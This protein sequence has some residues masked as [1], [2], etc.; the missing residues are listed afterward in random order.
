MSDTAIVI[1]KA[2]QAIEVALVEKASADP[3]F[4]AL[5]ISDPHKAVKELL[6]SDPLPSVK[7]RVIEEAEG[8]V[9][10]VLPRQMNQDELPDEILDLASGGFYMFLGGRDP[11]H[12][13]CK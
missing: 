13:L 12:K 1:A 4:R 3:A 7:M 8:E 6:G 2:R 10:L 5:L 11:N 9:V